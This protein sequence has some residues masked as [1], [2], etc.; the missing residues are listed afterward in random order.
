MCVCLA[1]INLFG[2]NLTYAQKIDFANNQFRLD[3]PKELFTEI[4]SS[5]QI[6]ANSLRFQKLI[7]SKKSK[8]VDI[9]KLPDKI[10][11]LKYLSFYVDDDCPPGQICNPQLLTVNNDDIGESM[12]EST[13]KVAELNHVWPNPFNPTTNI[14]FT[15]EKS[16]KVDLSVFTMLGHKV[17]TI[18]TKRLGKGNHTYIFDANELSSGVYMLRLQAGNNIQSQ[19]ITLIK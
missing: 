14:S 10:Y 15:L 11:D 4:N 13:L 7:D 9:V 6:R 19:Q 16:E 12:Q 5:S 8:R 2:Q 17:A 1:T 3:N 18:V